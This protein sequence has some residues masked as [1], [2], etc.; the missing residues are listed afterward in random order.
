MYVQI[1]DGRARAGCVAGYGC[2]AGLGRLVGA[3]GRCVDLVQDTKLP[4][5]SNR[6]VFV[7]STEIIPTV[8]APEGSREYDETNSCEGL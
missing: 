1:V 2:G 3:Y 4:F 5:E 8:T 7:R 6:V